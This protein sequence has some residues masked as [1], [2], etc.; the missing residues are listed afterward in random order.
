MDRLSYNLIYGIYIV[1]FGTNVEYRTARKEEY[2]QRGTEMLRKIDKGI[3][4]F[5]S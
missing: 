3:N 2:E 5:K 4:D 1:L